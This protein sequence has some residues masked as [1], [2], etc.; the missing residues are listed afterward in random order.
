MAFSRL[1][2]RILFTGLVILAASIVLVILAANQDFAFAGVIRL[3][4][5]AFLF[6]PFNERGCAII[7][8]LQPTLDIAGRSLAVP[9]HAVHRLLIDIG[10][11]GTTHSG[12]IKYRAAFVIEVVFGR[13]RVEI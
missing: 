8:D 9:G 3:S 5:H 2:T 4:N 10:T 7:A 13:N 6:H 1:A 11:L 12:R